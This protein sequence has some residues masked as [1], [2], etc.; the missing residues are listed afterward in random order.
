MMTRL[1]Q[2]VALIALS[3][4]VA[5]CAGPSAMMTT[6][7]T[8]PASTHM[9]RADDA[10]WSTR[11]QFARRMHRLKVQTASAP[12]TTGSTSRNSQASIPPL[13]EV[14]PGHR[15]WFGPEWEAE[16]RAE[17]ERLKRVTNICRC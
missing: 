1:Y 14:K 4:A 7:G 17:T 10:F 9:S 2:A 12:V 5:N 16:E 11:P 6:A 3:L 13:S 8:Q 15:R